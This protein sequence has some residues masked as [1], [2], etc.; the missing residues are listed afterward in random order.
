MDRVYDGVFRQSG[1]IRAYSIEELFDFCWCLGACP[2]PAGRGRWPLTFAA[3]K[4]WC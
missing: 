3:G 1:V 4:G 2:K